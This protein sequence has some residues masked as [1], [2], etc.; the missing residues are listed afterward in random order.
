MKEIELAN[1]LSN[2]TISALLVYQ[3]HKPRLQIRE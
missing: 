2:S 1:D 3:Y